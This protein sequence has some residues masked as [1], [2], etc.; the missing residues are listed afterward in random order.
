MKPAHLKEIN[1]RKFLLVLVLLCPT[2]AM[3]QLNLSVDL[4]T[5]YLPFSDFDHVRATLVNRFD[6]FEIISPVTITAYSDDDYFTGKR[7]A[8]FNVAGGSYELVVSIRNDTSA[9]VSSR[10]A[11]LSLSADHGITVV[12]TRPDSPT[13]TLESNLFFDADDDGLIGVGDIVR[14]NVRITG[15]AGAGIYRNRPA[16]GSTLLPRS[17]RTS[18]H[19]TVISGNGPID[20]VVEVQVDHVD[21]GDA[22]TISYEVQMT[23]VI[24]NQGELSTLEFDHVTGAILS[25]VIPTDDPDTPLLD[26]ATD[27]P[28]VPESFECASLAFTAS[29][30]LDELL[31][32]P[33]GD[34]LIAM[35]D[36]CPGTRPGAAVDEFGCSI[37][38]FCSMI[39]PTI[40]SGPALCSHADW[41]NDE[42]RSDNPKDCKAQNGLCLPL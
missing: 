32:D 2:S 28:A 42:P 9:V 4:R 18:I 12:L 20:N 24:T 19:G 17:V 21:A 16:P 37:E 14:Y 36:D 33:D 5:D 23:P 41:K 7:V 30:E 6:P 39:D 27:T 10:R 40:V 3:A 31:D 26:D 8:D 25:A 34:G 13:T 38:E 15:P 1:M 35:A 29:E 22:A 11:Q